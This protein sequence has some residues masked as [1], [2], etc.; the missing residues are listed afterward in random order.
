MFLP[1]TFTDTPHPTQMPWKAGEHFYVGRRY[2]E[3]RQSC[4]Q[5][6]PLPILTQ[7]LFSINSLQKIH[8]IKRIYGDYQPSRSW[9]SQ[10]CFFNR[11]TGLFFPWKTF[12][13]SSKKL[14]HF[15]KEYKSFYH[16]TPHH[17][18]RTE[19]AFLDEKPN[20]FK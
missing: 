6:M 12:G 1:I 16:P 3:N 20:V 17:S 4:S 7:A 10:W 19:K 2:E 8:F 18:V 15:C 9:L 14:L 11:Q 13:F 5:E